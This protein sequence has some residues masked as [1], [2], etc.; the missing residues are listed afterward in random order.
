MHELLRFLYDNICQENLIFIA[1]EYIKKV[2]F[3]QNEWFESY[4]TFKIYSIIKCWTKISCKYFIFKWNW[5]SD[6]KSKSY[7]LKEI[8]RR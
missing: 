4:L 8:T 2:I 1:D 3:S 5:N 7:Y 6:L